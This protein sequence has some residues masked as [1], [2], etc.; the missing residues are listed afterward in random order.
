MGKLAWLVV[1]QM[2]G[3]TDRWIVLFA[4]SVKNYVTFQFISHKLLV[5]CCPVDV[6]ST[7]TD[8]LVMNQSEEYRETQE[9][10][11]TGEV[12]QL[13]QYNKLYIV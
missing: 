2:D 12:L 10:R 13:V 5:F 1:G 9:K 3:W 11:Y 6:L 7:P 8:M 4:V